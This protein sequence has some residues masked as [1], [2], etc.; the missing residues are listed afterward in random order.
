VLN[1]ENATSQESTSLT[2]AS[3]E[4]GRSLAFALTECGCKVYATICDLSD[5][6]NIL[7]AARDRKVQVACSCRPSSPNAAASTVLVNNAEAGRVSAC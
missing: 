2:G 4:V 6:D 1:R 5:P 3:T 7:R